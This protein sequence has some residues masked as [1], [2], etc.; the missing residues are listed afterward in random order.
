MSKQ[1]LNNDKTKNDSA[2]STGYIK[3]K[4]SLTNTTQLD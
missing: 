3:I 2:D 4:F 1:Q